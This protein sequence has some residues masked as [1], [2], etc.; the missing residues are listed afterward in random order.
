MKH[1]KKIL[2]LSKRETKTFDERFI[3]LSEEIG[4]IAVAILQ[5]RNLKGTTKTKS[6]IKENILEEICDSIIILLSLASY[7]KFTEN[8]INEMVAK[9]L[10]KW[11]SRLKK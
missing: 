1:T 10:K 6:E 7:H 4:E 2:S 8:Q 11:E 9:K 3:K 5:S